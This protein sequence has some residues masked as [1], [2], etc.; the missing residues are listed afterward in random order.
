VSFRPRRALKRKEATGTETELLGR[1]AVANLRYDC[2]EAVASSL[3]G[4]G[5]S[6]YLPMHVRWRKLPK[7]EARKQGVTRELVSSAL[8]P[9]YL[10]VEVQTSY[11]IA[12]T[13]GHKDVFGFISTRHGIC[14]IKDEDIESL[15]EAEAS[16]VHDAKQKKLAVKAEAPAVIQV[17]CPVRE[18]LKSMGLGSLM[19]QSIILSSGPF[20]GQTGTVSKDEGLS[21][22]VDIMS[23]K[24][25]APL[26][27]IQLA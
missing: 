5:I 23:M 14:F 18:K 7:H 13:F 17:I 22:S 26:S 2:E 10:F 15:R 20:A 12:A 1:W 9:G 21:V 19:G 27:Q 8:I 11:D 25:T 6:T 3:Q 24:V 4:N 16:K